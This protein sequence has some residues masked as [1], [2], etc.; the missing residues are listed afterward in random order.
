MLSEYLY[1]AETNA[2]LKVQLF[3]E[4]NEILTHNEVRITQMD[5]AWYKFIDE[6]YHIENDYL[7]FLD[8]VKFNIVPSY[9]IDNVDE[10]VSG[11]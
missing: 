2:Y 7:H 1:N 10:I 3:R 5:D 4:M 11:I 8:I 6:T 9:I